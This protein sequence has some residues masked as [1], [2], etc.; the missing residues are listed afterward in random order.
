MFTSPEALRELSA[1][2]SGWLTRLSK[3]RS[4]QGLYEFLTREYLSITPGARV[5]TVGSGGDVNR[6]LTDAATRIGF[7]MCSI[8]IDPDRAPD[9]VGDICRIP[10]PA[11]LFDVVVVAEV[12]EHVKRPADAVANLYGALKPGGK[13]I[14]TTPFVFPMHD[15]PHDYFR[16][17]KH[18]LDLLLQDFRNVDIQARNSYYEAIDVLWVRLLQTHQRS[19]ALLCFIAIPFIYFIKRP[20]T[21][22]LT[23]LF[24]CDAMTTGYVATALK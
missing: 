15:R 8:D 24:P 14:L 4:R 18:G 16:F 13:L 3:L 6:L 1:S 7:D 22:L 12:L 11:N 5:L 23:K 21:L 17:T 9:I 20:L 10:L 2:Y 19:T